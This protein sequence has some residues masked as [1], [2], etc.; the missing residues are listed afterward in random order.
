MILTNAIS[1][2]QPQVLRLA[3]DDLYRGV[4][5]EKLG[6]YALVLFAIA[7]VG[8]AFRYLMRR[9]VIGISRHVEFDL[10]NHVFA[11]LQRLPVDYFQHT[12]TGE[13]LSRAT[14][15][16]A[17][18]RMMLGPGILYFVNTVTVAA[19]SLGFMLAISPR[20]TFY[21][22]LP[23][24]LVSLTVWVF[25]DRIHRRFEE[26]QAHFAALSARVQENVSGV[27]V[28]RAFAREPHE[29]EDFGAI[30]R[31]YLTKNLALIRTWGVFHPLLAF[32]AGLAALLALY[33]GGREVI[34][35]RITLGEF[36]AFT[37]YLGMLNWPVVAL[38]WVINLFQRGMASYRR[39]DEILAVVPA[40]GNE[41]GAIAPEQCRGELEFRDLTFTYPG[42]ERP[43]LQSV[44][45]HVTPGA[46]VAL[47]GATGSGKSTVLSL[48]PR[49]FDPPPGTV[50]LDGVDVRRYDLRWLRNQIAYVPQDT[51]LFSA[52]L[53]ENIAYGVRDAT[54]ESVVRAA[55]IAHLQDDVSGFPDG[56]QTLVGERGI[57]LSGGQR[58]RTA[59][60]RALL[61]NSPILMLD[62]CLSSV[63]THT[64]EAILGGLRREL[65]RR[66]AL[67]V[68]HRVSTVRDADLIV[69]LEDGAVVERGTHD[70]LLAL[71]GRYARLCRQ[72][73]LE[74]ELEAS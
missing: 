6:G 15:D 70:S 51:F 60:A 29:L 30:H 67:L 57:T 53:E 10:R 20:A 2:A 73:E 24:P 66:T 1:L 14:N 59:I 54:P 64:E 8:G 56:Y 13:I 5:A 36:V 47:V 69:V 43:A 21:S 19:V 34:K 72:Q 71:G 33:L 37:A 23:L 49:I 63:D 17:A 25:G 35:D 16:L 39:I 48:L 26:I 18:V 32:L 68:S 27:R 42:E 28:V 7:L 12:R 38:G 4:T 9:V 11:H 40:I 52:T 50:F 46:T 3:V 62:D 22:L 74:D 44:S 55:H 61:R 31:D 41:P 45:F 58:Q 65:R